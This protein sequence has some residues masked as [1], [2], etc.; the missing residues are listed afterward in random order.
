[1]NCVICKSLMNPVGDNRYVCPKCGR[2]DYPAW[3]Q[4]VE[5]YMESHG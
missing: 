5:S 3:Y 4:T 2:H 1:M